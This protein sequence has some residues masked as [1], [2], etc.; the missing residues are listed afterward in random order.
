MSAN[1][2][3]TW[4]ALVLVAFCG[5]S[6]ATSA[7]EFAEPEGV[8]PAADIQLAT[9][10]LPIDGLAPGQFKWY[11]SAVSGPV[12]IIV[13]LSEQRA[14]VFRGGERIAVSTI[15]S[16][17]PGKDTPTGVFPI[18][19]KKKLH[20][21]NLYDNAPMP[22]MQRLTWDGVALHAGRIPGKPASH[23]CIR[24]PLEFARQLFAM[25]EHG[26][27]VVVSQDFSTQALLQVGVPE[28]MAQQ[29]GTPVDV[30]ATASAELVGVNDNDDDAFAE[31]HAM[32]Y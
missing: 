4:S 16:G 9:D 25:T 19:Q 28:W 27:T 13:G 32:A 22:F 3:S 30:F 17:K 12:V 2:F 6:S 11:E 24:L 21:S 14:H 18:L 31:I 20:H 8:A 26:E 23:G 7:Q 15:S 1:K 29:L 10:A 5:F